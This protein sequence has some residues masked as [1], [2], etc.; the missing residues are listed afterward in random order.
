M[1][2]DLI[3]EIGTEEVPAGF[4]P[5]AL[6]SLEG[7]FKKSLDANHLSHKGLKTLGTPRRLT[8][9]VKALEEKQRDASTEVKGPARR[10]AFDE[11]GK[12]TKA[13]L[14][15]A[16]SQ[17]VK[18][19]ELKA[20]KTEKGEYLYAI[21]KV[22]GERTKKILPGALKAI[23]SSLTFPK[24][25]RWSDHEISFA[26]PIHWILA[27]YGGEPVRFDFG[28]IKSGPNTF[29]HR[30]LGGKTKVA[31]PRPIR[32]KSVK[33]YFEKLEA[34]NVMVDP[35]ERK[36][37]I[38][39]GLEKEAKS[40]NGEVLTDEGLLREVTDLVE[41]PVVVMGSFESEFLKLP[42]D[43]V[44]NAMREHQRYFSVVDGKGD[45][46]PYFITVANT[47]AT[48]PGVVRRGNERVLKARL[49]DAKF[50]FE[51]D[52]ASPLSEKVEEL[53]GVVFQAKL[54]TSFEK[55]LRF[56]ELALYI[57]NKLGHSDSIDASESFE[58]FLKEKYDPARYE[59]AETEAGHYKK[60]VLGRASMLSKA[61]LTSGMVGKARR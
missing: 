47:R 28:H 19:E 44:I 22:Q 55:V 38:S 23:V 32:V 46:L 53:K 36:K 21:K 57:G 35:E 29:G 10:A 15:F 12:P 39:A 8:I 11:S 24:A 42:R 18:V 16:G 4:I 37:T 6:L 40:V 31:K 34:A 7:L 5:G 61:D 49:N 2:K 52:M 59:K 33:E 17:G 58:D 50:Y 60:L 9:I 30:F 26:R 51:K 1:A 56:T 3:L 13:L 41:Y 54:G 43:V 25:M 14:G 20:V 45:L 27:L 48:D